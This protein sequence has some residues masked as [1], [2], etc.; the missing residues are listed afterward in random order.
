MSSL[1]HLIVPGIIVLVVLVVLGAGLKTVEQAHVGVVTMFGKYRRTVNAGLNIVI[2]FFE[3]IL[4]RVPVQNQTTPM[5]FAAITGDQAAVHFKATITYTVSDHDPATI[6]L[7]A[8]KFINIQAFQRAMSSAIEAAVREFVAQK[9]QAEVLGLRTEI[10]EHAKANLSEQLA[11]WGYTLVDLVV[12]DITF[13][14]EVMASMSRVVAAINAQRAAE[15][16]GEA[17]RITRTK[18]AEAEGAAIKIAAEAEAQAQKLRGEGLANFRKAMVEGWTTAAEE[19]RQSGLT[20]DV[21]MMALWTETMSDVARNGA[22][23]VIFFD[24]SLDGEAAARKRLH[25][26]LARQGSI[27]AAPSGPAREGSLPKDG[28]TVAPQH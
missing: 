23:N 6:Q 18:A 2:P 10:V 12:N 27:E 4:V 21:L 19:L 17:L 9:E 20:E 14:P 13:D 25:G 16:E 7:V 3:R 11:T 24:G 8:F 1:S 15:S 5:E 26:L 28:P 22:G